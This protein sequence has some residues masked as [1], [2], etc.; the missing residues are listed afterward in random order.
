MKEKGSEQFSRNQY[1][2]IPDPA[3]RIGELARCEADRSDAIGNQSVGRG[4]VQMHAE[5]QRRFTG[6]TLR[7]Q[8]AEDSGEHVAGPGARHAGV[9]GGVDEEMAVARDEHAAVSLEHYVRVVALGERTGR[10]ETILLNLPRAPAKES[11]RF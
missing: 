3:R 2:A 1:P 11:S 8:A 10:G 6:E 4:A 5:H 9:A 7:E